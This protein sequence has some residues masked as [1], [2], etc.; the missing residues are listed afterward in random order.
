LAVQKRN[1][2]LQTELENGAS[3]SLYRTLI[4]I[5]GGTTTGWVK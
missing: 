4:T 2:K 3:L 1:H 5:K